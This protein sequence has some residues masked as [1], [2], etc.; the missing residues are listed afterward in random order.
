MCV[1]L[2]IINS[3]LQRI[4][5]STVE[6]VQVKTVELLRSLKKVMLSNVSS[7]E[8]TFTEVRGLKEAIH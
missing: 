7:G 1:V 5:F 4:H 6:E 3:A 8:G 2:S